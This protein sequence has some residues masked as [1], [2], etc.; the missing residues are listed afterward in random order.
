MKIIW[1]ILSKLIASII[2]W[3]LIS[4]ALLLMFSFMSWENLFITNSW[5]EAFYFIFRLAWMVSFIL[6]LSINEK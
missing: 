3:A 2:L 5:I 4:V 6:L 1:I